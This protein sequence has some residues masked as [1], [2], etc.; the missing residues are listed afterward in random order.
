LLSPRPYPSFLPL[1]FQAA[2][3]PP[4]LSLTEA[5]VLQVILPAAPTARHVDIES[6]SLQ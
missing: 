5:E 2:N 3:Q 4:V 1:H 6:V